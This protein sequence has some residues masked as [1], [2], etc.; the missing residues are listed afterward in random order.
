MREDGYAYVL[1]T[2]SASLRS[3]GGFQWPEEG[4][5]R[6]PDWNT[7]RKCGGGL[8]GLLW[9]RGN[10]N[11]LDWSSDAKWL[12]VRVRA[13]T[14]IDLLDKVKF[15]EG[16][17]ECCGTR[18]KAIAYLKSKSPLPL[19]GLV[20]DIVTVGDYCT[21]TAGDYGTATAG[22][23]GSATAGNCGSATAGEHG[24]AT[25]GDFGAATVGDYGVAMAGRSGKASAGKGGVIQIK[26]FDGNRMRVAIGYVGEDGIEPDTAYRVEDGKLV[27]ANRNR[28]HDA[29]KAREQGALSI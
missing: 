4:F 14:L 11:L 26:W 21:A 9:G 15:P 2:C 7:K 23:C 12:V 10:G 29:D 6:A 8:H 25:V 24:A 3:R 1:R 16:W 18:E 17:V 5:V 22:A 19:H 27:P 20:G 13:D 28:K